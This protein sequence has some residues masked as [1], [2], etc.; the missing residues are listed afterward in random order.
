MHLASKEVQVKLFGEVE[1]HNRK[2]KIPPVMEVAP[3]YELH[4]YCL[5]CLHYFTVS[6]YTL[7][8]LFELFSLLPLLTLFTFILL[9][10]LKLLYTA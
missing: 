5:N 9:I 6:V 10:P 1:C 3:Y 4:V 2:I 8:T 7:L